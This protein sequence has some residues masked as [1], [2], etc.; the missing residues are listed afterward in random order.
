M[1]LYALTLKNAGR[2]LS[3]RL[4]A[5]YTNNAM[6]LVI[7]GPKLAKSCQKLPKYRAVTFPTRSKRELV[8]NLATRKKRACKRVF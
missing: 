6:L 8:G 4:V 3:A 2:G 7:A 1:N 5:F